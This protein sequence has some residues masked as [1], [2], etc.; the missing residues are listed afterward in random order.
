VVTD[1]PLVS[2]EILLLKEE[3][4]IGNIDRD[5]VIMPFATF[6]YVFQG[7]FLVIRRTDTP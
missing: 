4:A 7:I 2:S 5:L 1:Y 6:Y 3:G